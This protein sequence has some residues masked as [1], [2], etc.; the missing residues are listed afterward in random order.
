MRDR[1]LR[2]TGLPLDRCEVVGEAVPFGVDPL[3]RATLEGGVSKSGF[4]RLLA[5]EGVLDGS[6]TGGVMGSRSH[7]L[8]GGRFVPAVRGSS[9]VNVGS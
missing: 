8:T 5:S 2:E 1:K 4:T 9:G 3:V 6:A 7:S